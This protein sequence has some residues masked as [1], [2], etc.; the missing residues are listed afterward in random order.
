[1]L[2]TLGQFMTNRKTKCLTIF[3]LL[4]KRYEYE[5]LVSAR[6]GF[7]L[8]SLHGDLDS[9]KYFINNGYK[10]NRFRKNYKKA[11]E[12]AREIVESYDGSMANMDCRLER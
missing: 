3:E 12:L 10:S 11:L 9:L 8:P 5:T 7:N 4:N 2:L 1:M 6:K